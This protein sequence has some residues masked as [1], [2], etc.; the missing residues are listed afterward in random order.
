MSSIMQHQYT[1]LY[2]RLKAYDPGLTKLWTEANEIHFDLSIH[3]QKLKNLENRLCDSNQS[4]TGPAISQIA[5]DHNN[6]SLR[7]IVLLMT[8]ERNKIQM[9][10]HEEKSIVENFKTRYNTVLEEHD[11]LCREA[12]IIDNQICDIA[13]QIGHDTKLK[14]NREME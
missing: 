7:R 1:L 12:N 3:S 11:K 5:G 14:W 8:L 9:R 10:I 13:N 6:S 4:L 2:K